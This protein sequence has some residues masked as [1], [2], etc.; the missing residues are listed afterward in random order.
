M[1]TLVALV[2]VTVAST[3]LAQT[4][5]RVRGTIVALDGDVMKVKARDGRDLQLNLAS[6]VQVVTAKKASLADFPPGSY[7]GVTSVREPGVTL[8]SAS[9]SGVIS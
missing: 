8:V 2:L 7:V 9:S 6:D 4:N 5:V 1:K 3:A